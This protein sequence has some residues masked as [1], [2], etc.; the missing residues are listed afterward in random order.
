MM[1]QSVSRKM[2]LAWSQ[3]D[4]SVSAYSEILYVVYQLSIVYDLK[5]RPVWRGGEGLKK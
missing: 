2:F 4:F 1:L 5:K 3:K